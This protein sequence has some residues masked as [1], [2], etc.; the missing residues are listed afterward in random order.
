L[1]Q[2]ELSDGIIDRPLGQVAEDDWMFVL[3][4][5]QSWLVLLTWIYETCSTKTFLLAALLCPASYHHG[6]F[7]SLQQLVMQPDERNMLR[8]ISS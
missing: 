1:Q 3:L 4:D 6:V 7:S 5:P 8:V 2:S